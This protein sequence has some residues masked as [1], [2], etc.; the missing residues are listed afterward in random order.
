[1]AFDKNR[2]RL[3]ASEIKKKKKKQVADPGTELAT[4]TFNSASGTNFSRKTV[5]ALF[6][7]AVGVID[8]TTLRPEDT[9]MHK[10]HTSGVGTYYNN[11]TCTLRRRNNRWPGD[12]G[13]R[14][15]FDTTQRYRRRRHRRNVKHNVSGGREGGGGEKERV[16]RAHGTTSSR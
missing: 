4:V 9:P 13:G 14:R 15:S 5:L 11:M 8:N 10:R 1:M 2:L 7:A 16:R 12:D 6:T 3:S